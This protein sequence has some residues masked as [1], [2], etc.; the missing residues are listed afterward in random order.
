MY[1]IAWGVGED[2]DAETTTWFVLEHPYKEFKYFTHKEALFMR[3]AEVKN[4]KKKKSEKRVWDSDFAVSALGSGYLVKKLTEEARV[5]KIQSNYCRLVSV[6]SRESSVLGKHSL[7]KVIQHL[8][9]AEHERKDQKFSRTCLTVI[10]MISKP[11]RYKPMF[12][13]IL[14]WYKWGKCPDSNLVHVENDWSNKSKDLH[15]VLKVAS[16]LRPDQLN[17]L[18]ENLER[19][20]ELLDNENEWG[21]YCRELQEVLKVMGVLKREELTVLSENWTLILADTNV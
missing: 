15:N 10:Q 8:S 16:G 13:F 19:I 17:L 1:Y 20:L 12:D 11:A 4:K 5:M 14:L 2:P 7:I 3:E 21:G 9:R 6:G 18:S